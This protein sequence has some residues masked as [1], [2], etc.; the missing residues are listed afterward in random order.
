MH[1]DKLH[2]TQ[3]IFYGEVKIYAKKRG[4]TM[5]NVSLYMVMYG[6]CIV[7]NVMLKISIFCVR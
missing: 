3:A 5:H 1:D 7:K 4:H 6:K 2:C